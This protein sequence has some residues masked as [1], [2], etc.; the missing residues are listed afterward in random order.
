MITRMSNW[1]GAR[2]TFVAL[3]VGFPLATPGV[4]LGQ[5]AETPATLGSTMAITESGPVMGGSI[6]LVWSAVPDATHYHVRVEDAVTLQ[7]DDYYPAEAASCVTGG[8]VCTVTLPT[9]G[10]TPG[11]GQWTV[12]A[13]SATA[14]GPWTEPKVFTYVEVSANG[15]PF[16]G[17]VTAATLASAG[18]TATPTLESTGPLSAEGGD[19]PVTQA[20]GANSTWFGIDA[21]FSETSGDFN[22]AFGASA[23]EFTTTGNY[24]VAAGFSALLN[25][26]TGSHNT[27]S[28][29]NALL[30]NT[31]GSHN[32]A[33]GRNA[34]FTNASGNYN[35]AEGRSALYSNTTGNNNTASGRS[36]L[37]ANVTGSNNM[38]SGSFALRFNTTGSYNTA[39]GRS[40]LYANTSGSYNTAVG[41]LAG[42][43]L[44]SG[45][46]NLYLDNPGQAIESETIRIGDTQTRTFVAGVWGTTPG[47]ADAQPVVID[48]AGQLG[49]GPVFAVYA[50]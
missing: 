7:V 38:A 42:D 6:T 45:D 37:F 34:L 21:L 50:P 35:T 43:S 41:Y 40:A 2:L 22:S 5:G 13:W 27:A 12:Q 26:T 49:T 17:G 9:T 25:N 14:E 33:S 10:F 46:N 31:T 18:P 44:T 29:M 16:T 23:L 24:N 19:G 39:T 1:T 8:G 32:T 28:G 11:T 48:S 20:F 3:L 30:S 4:V 15:T 47:V 36:A